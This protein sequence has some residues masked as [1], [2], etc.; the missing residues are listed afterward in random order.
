MSTV[1]VCASCGSENSVSS[2]FCLNCGSALNGENKTKDDGREVGRAWPEQGWTPTDGGVEAAAKKQAAPA[3]QS[4]GA[5]TGYASS[6]F[7]AGNYG[8]LRGL[9]QL[10]R[11][12]G[13]LFVGAAVLGGLVG[14]FMMTRSFT[15]G[16][17]VIVSSALFGVFNYVL[18]RL[19]GESISVIIDIEANTRR[20]AQLLEEWGS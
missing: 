3:R 5:Q 1:T 18:F 20:T 9:A 8:A 19:L 2:K 14:L 7:A 17:G 13:F 10:C 16:L 11:F 12:I 15:A 6:S 4:Q